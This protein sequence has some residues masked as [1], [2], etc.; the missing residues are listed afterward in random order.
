MVLWWDSSSKD[1]VFEVAFFCC[2]VRES[3]STVPMLDAFLPLS[4]IDRAINPIHFTKAFSFTHLEFSLIDITALTPSESTIPMSIIIEVLS[5]I[6]VAC[7]IIFLAF[8]LALTM[9]E[10][11]PEVSFVE[12][13]V[14][15]YVLSVALKLSMLVVT[16]VDI[17]VGE[18]FT[19]FTVL[20]KPFPFPFIAISVF[21]D[22]NA[23]PF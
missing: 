5:F 11:F 21:V 17:S 8:P 3:N 7:W 22:V 18:K 12:R 1:I 23:V 14:V 15:R 2:T 9:L 13:T 16:Y 4:Y 19:S 20:E 6:G 10:A